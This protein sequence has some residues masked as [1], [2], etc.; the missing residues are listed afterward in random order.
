VQIIGEDEESETVVADAEQMT[1]DRDAR[2]NRVDVHA[3]WTTPQTSAR[4]SSSPSPPLSAVS[5]PPAV[6]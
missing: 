1:L 2:E 6:G 4:A 3:T 5:F